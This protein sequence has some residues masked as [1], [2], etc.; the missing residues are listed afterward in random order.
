MWPVDLQV[1]PFGL[2][3]RKTGNRIFM[4]AFQLSCGQYCGQPRTWH[5]TISL[6]MKTQ[7]IRWVY[8]LRNAISNEITNKK[9]FSSVIWRK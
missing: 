7:K 2:R 5:T 8:L 4:K 1:I 9:A 6:G 3:I